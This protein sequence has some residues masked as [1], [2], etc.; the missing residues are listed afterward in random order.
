MSSPGHSRPERTDRPARRTRGCVA[1]RSPSGA[2]SP[3]WRAGTTRGDPR[4]RRR[5]PPGLLAD[6]LRAQHR[7]PAGQPAVLVHVVDR[8]PW[9]GHAANHVG[10]REDVAGWGTI[11]RSSRP[12]PSAR[13][14]CRSPRPVP[15]RRLSSQYP[16]HRTARARQG[17][18]GG[19]PVMRPW[20][21]TASFVRLT[22]LV[23]A[24]HF[25]V[26]TRVDL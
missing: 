16:T 20:S 9:R 5:R 22:L 19:G 17:R 2:T 23:Q 18:R 15:A 25:G 4:G 14:T 11:P 1:G 24:E 10:H 13:R 26:P 6:D 21:P 7:E 3:G 8:N 12:Q